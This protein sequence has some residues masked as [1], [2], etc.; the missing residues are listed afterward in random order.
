ML[1]VVI[2]VAAVIAMVGIGDGA[3][4]SVANRINKLGTNLL[5]VRPGMQ[6]FRY[7]RYIDGSEELYDKVAATL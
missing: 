6:R 5:I 1:G 7:I 3:K 2:G 4:A